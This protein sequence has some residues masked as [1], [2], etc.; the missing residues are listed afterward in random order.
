MSQFILLCRDKPDSV[1]LR[2]ETRTEHLKY[3]DSFGE[4]LMLAGP[5]L[6]ENGDPVGSLI[7]VEAKDEQA[8]REIADND[9]Y[10]KA[11]LFA[12]VDIIPFKTV[13][14]NISKV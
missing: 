13:I 3:A 4:R 7:I 14:A 5:M 9:P 12:S 8:A 11:G 2:M 6:N 1:A 10:A